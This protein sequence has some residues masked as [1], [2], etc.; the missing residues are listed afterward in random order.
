[1]YERRLWYIWH[2]FQFG[3]KWKVTRDNENLLSAFATSNEVNKNLI[4]ISERNWM[5]IKMIASQN[6]S[7][8]SRQKLASSEFVF[9]RFFSSSEN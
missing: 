3:F 2:S 9:F 6:F 7:E 8:N 1:M 5:F 4:K